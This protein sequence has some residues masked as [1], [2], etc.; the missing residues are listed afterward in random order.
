M[1]DEFL[2][3]GQARTELFAVKLN[4]DGN[5]YQF[6]RAD[7]SAASENAHKV[8]EMTTPVISTKPTY[9]DQGIP[10]VDYDYSGSG[11]TLDDFLT[12]FATPVSVATIPEEKNEAGVKIG[13]SASSVPQTVGIIYGKKDST[14]KIRVEVFLNRCL[15]SSKS[16]TQKDGQYAKHPI[17]FQGEAAEIDLEIPAFLF[18]SAVVTPAPVT[19]KQ[20]TA[21]TVVWMA[22]A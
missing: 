2:V 13:G 22:G 14:G 21:S 10:K 7:D 16:H 8:F 17:A 19:I 4:N 5:A 6:I 18:N 12:K 15:A 11:Q 3:G 20:Y 9:N 1:S